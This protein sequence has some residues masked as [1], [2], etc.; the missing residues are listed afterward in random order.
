MNSVFRLWRISDQSVVFRF[1][2]KFNHRFNQLDI[3]IGIDLPLFAVLDRKDRSRLHLLTGTMKDGECLA[4]TDIGL[5]RNGRSGTDGE[6]GGFAAFTAVKHFLSAITFA[7][8]TRFQPD[9]IH[10]RF[11]I[12][13]PVFLRHKNA[14]P[15]CRN[16]KVLHA[17]R[18]DR[19]IEMIDD[20]CIFTLII[21]D[22]LSDILIL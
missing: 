11:Q 7:D 10:N 17:H 20:Q 15:A 8:Y 2:F 22:D 9:I 21:P 14:I 13:N 12:R 1:D 18:K 5:D 3:R 19:K 16:D 6:Q 4:D